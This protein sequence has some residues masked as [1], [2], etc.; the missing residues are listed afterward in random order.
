[1]RGK[2]AGRGGVGTGPRPRRGGGAAGWGRGTGERSGV[3]VEA[4]RE[5]IPAGSAEVGKTGE[6]LV[7]VLS[8]DVRGYTEMSGGTAPAALADRISSLQ[9][10]ASQ[11]VARQHGIID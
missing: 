1:M 8:A 9:R 11:E 10:W 7:S 5:A 2:A 4:P 3:L 6:R